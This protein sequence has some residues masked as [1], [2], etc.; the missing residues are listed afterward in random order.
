MGLNFL[1]NQAIYFDANIFIYLFERNIVYAPIIENV[2]I[3]IL[4]QRA[5]VITSE[6]TLMECLI[7]P[8]RKK[9]DALIS[10]YQNYLKN[11]NTLLL[12]PISRQILIESSTLRANSRIKTPDAIHLATADLTGCSLF[13]TNDQPL[14]AQAM[15]DSL[16]LSDLT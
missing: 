6:L 9:N 1:K 12:E 13:F 4:Q 8:I 3:K 14:A 2:F 7:L 10:Q 11:G 15:M 16:L 5:R